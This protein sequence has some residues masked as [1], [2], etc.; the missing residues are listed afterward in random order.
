[1]RWWQCNIREMNFDSPRTAMEHIASYLMMI[2]FE[3]I[4]CLSRSLF[5]PPRHALLRVDG[6]IVIKRHK[7]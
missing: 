2:L 7:F 3:N 6:E 1:M 4:C 5:T